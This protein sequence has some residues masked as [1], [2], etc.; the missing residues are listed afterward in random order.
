MKFKELRPRGKSVAQKY[1]DASEESY[2]PVK[3]SRLA[4][5]ESLGNFTVKRHRLILFQTAQ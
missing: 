2:L 3:L 5:I 4:Y 1:A